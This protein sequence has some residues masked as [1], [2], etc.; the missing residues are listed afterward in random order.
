[1]RQ[2]LIILLLFRVTS[3]VG[4][5]PTF[6][7][8]LDKGTFRMAP[9]PAENTVYVLPDS[10]VA[11]VHVLIYDDQGRNVLSSELNGPIELDVSTLPA[12]HYM[13]TTM[14]RR[15]T[16]LDVHRLLIAR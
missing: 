6:T 3:A 5:G 13:V 4:Q 8:N 11:G 2:L 14:N 7:E 1:M 9:N 12:G 10:S 16:P 15:G